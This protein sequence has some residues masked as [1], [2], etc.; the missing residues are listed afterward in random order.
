MRFGWVWAAVAAGVRV[1]RRNGVDSVRSALSRAPSLRYRSAIHP[2]PAAYLT[3]RG[4]W[5]AECSHPTPTRDGAATNATT[6]PPRTY[7]THMLGPTTDTFAIE[8][9]I[10]AGAMWIEGRKPTCGDM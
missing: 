1:M 10:I 7:T 3:S 9:H 5:A 2:S 4:E 8:R 6:R